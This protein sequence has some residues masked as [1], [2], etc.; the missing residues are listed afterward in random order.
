MT[1]KKGRGTN[2]KYLPYAFTELGVAMLSSVLRSETAIRVNRDIMRALGKIK[3]GE[4]KGKSYRS[5][6]ARYSCSDIKI[7]EF[8]LYISHLIVPL[9]VKTN[10]HL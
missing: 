10:P 9:Q 6:R 7:N 3:L 2:I 1:M 8:I 4:H 5:L